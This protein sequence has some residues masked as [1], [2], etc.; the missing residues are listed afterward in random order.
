MTG[1]T[2]T[3]VHA[4][5]SSLLIGTLL[6]IELSNSFF[7]S[8]ALS[9]LIGLFIGFMSGISFGLLAIADGILSG[10]MGGMMGAMTGIMTEAKFSHT[11][12]QLLFLIYFIACFIIYF[13]NKTNNV[14]F[15]RIYFAFLLAV[16]LTFTNFSFGSQQSKEASS[17]QDVIIEAS[18]YSFTPNLLNIQP[19]KK[20]KITVKNTGKEEHRFKLFSEEHNNHPLIVTVLPGESES[21]ILTPNHISEYH[22]ICTM[23]GHKEKGMHGKIE[24][25]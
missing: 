1:M 15:R 11:L 16:L 24:V 19:D 21:I 8:T 6:G 7:L 23:P 14:N 10:V 12:I 20:V 22:F 25:S 13:L 9:I 5:S 2:I 3:M 18:E 17:E 4:M